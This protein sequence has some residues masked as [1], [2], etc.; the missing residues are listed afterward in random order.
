MNTKKLIIALSLLLA[1]FLQTELKAQWRTST[2][3]P[4]E[5]T[6]NPTEF[7]KNA[8][9]NTPDALINTYSDNCVLNPTNHNDPFAVMYQTS[10]KHIKMSQIGNMYYNRFMAEG[11]GSDPQYD[12]NVQTDYYFKTDIENSRLILDATST[13]SSGS[14]F[15]YLTFETSNITL[16]QSTTLEGSLQARD[17]T[18][19]NFTANQVNTP[20]LSCSGSGFI[21][22]LTTNSLNLNNLSIGAKHPTGAYANY[23]LSVDGTIV[24]K[25]EIVQITSWA[26]KVFSKDYKMLSLF[27]LEKYVNQYKHLP[28]IPSEA[29]VIK[30][31]VDVAE[32]NKLLLQKVEELTLHL[33]ELNKKI[34]KL[35]AKKQ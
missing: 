32:M 33:I 8:P 3:M 4:L 16:H 10:Y 11:V 14:Y 29:D 5:Y 25:K 22:N 9:Y 6:I 12:C 26:D 7:G 15:K 23:S 30:N 19:D 1:T 2:T 31:G 27:E 20:T 17:I 28:E 35:E 18:A 34:E 21:N 13:R 24:S